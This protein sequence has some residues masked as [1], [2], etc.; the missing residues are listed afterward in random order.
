MPSQKILDAKKQ[1]VSNLVAEYKNAQSFVFVDA[2]GLTVE[3]DTAMRAEFRKNN[4]KYNVLKN[5]TLSITFKELGVEGLDEDFKGPTAI[6]YSTEDLIAPAKI[7]KQY[8]DKYEKMTIKG[9]VIENKRASVDEVNTLASI[10][11][12]EVLC[13]QI[14][15]GMLFPITKL[16]MLVKAV[17]EK[18]EANGDAA[19]VAAEEAPVAEAPVAEE[20]KTEAAVEAPVE[21]PATEAAPEA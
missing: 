13:G 11:T 17:A 18:Q 8:A 9:G 14:V 5:T 16:A 4:V 15:Y 19:P 12:K 10:P 21:A 6:A 20:A 7:A 1:V 2:R 3:E